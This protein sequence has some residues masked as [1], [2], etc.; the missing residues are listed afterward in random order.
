MNIFE[1]L[2]YRKILERIV[3]ERKQV[4]GDFRFHLMASAM[5]IQKSYLSR[6]IHGHAELNSDQLFLACK[7]LG[8]DENQI[9][10]MELLLDYAKSN[11]P[12]KKKK[13]A[14]AIERHQSENLESQAHIKARAAASGDSGLT[15][16]YVDPLNQIV[17]ICLLIKRYRESPALLAEDLE[18]APARLLKSI[19]LLEKLGIIAQS[20]G[21]ISVLLRQL[22]LP[23][24]AEVYPIW[25]DQLK[26]M[27]LQRL[28]TLPEGSDYSF[29]VIFSSDKKTKEKIQRKFLNLLKDIEP[30]VEKANDENVFQMSFDL[31]GWTGAG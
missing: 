27:S 2:D 11:V 16:Y 12:E 3:T 24:D 26:L 8:L 17:H 29:S 25:R 22:H 20:E 14:V 30:L 19:T 15:L 13:L 1:E 31:F 9:S 10:Y 23:R 4:D 5:R 28:K 6:V 21:K 18:L 7:Y